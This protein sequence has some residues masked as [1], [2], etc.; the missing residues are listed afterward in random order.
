MLNRCY[1]GGLLLCLLLIFPLW[2]C[3]VIASDHVADDCGMN[4]EDA[5]ELFT[6]S[7]VEMYHRKGVD[8]GVDHGRMADEYRQLFGEFA[9]DGDRMPCAAALL[10]GD[11]HAGTRGRPVDQVAQVDPVQ[12]TSC[13]RPSRRKAACLTST[14]S[15]FSVKTLR[16]F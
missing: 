5:L 9:G 12:Q 7:M 4:R 6:R 16:F 10:R 1:L 13:M 8:E 3:S 2:G 15:G 14:A 11:A